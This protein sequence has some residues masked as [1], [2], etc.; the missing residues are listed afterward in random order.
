MASQGDGT[1]VWFI[2]GC[3]TGLGHALAER[4]L[5]HGHRC[6]VTARNVAQIEAIAAP[7][8]DRALAVALDVTD[9]AQVDR[10]LAEAD[11]KFGRID[12]LVNNA[13]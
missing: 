13:G 4:V 10:A 9:S 8:P 2:T 5:A 11:R 7:Y 3:S 12:V 6:V 1:P